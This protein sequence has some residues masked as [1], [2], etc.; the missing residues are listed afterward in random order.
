MIGLY[1]FFV[2]SSVEIDYDIIF[3]FMLASYAYLA[4]ENN[5]IKRRSEN[6][7]IKIGI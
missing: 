3:F 7:K 1:A 4:P 6:R 2:L 5:Y